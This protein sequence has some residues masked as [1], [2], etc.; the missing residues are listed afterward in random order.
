[1]KQKVKVAIRRGLQHALHQQYLV[2]V[3]LVAKSVTISWQ[4]RSTPAAPDV[5]ALAEE[6]LGH[7][8]L[9][10]SLS[11]RKDKI[12]DNVPRD[13]PWADIHATWRQLSMDIPMQLTLSP[14]GAYVS[15][16]ERIKQE[17]LVT[18][19]DEVKTALKGGVRHVVVRLALDNT[20]KWSRGIEVASVALKEG[21]SLAVWHPVG[22]YFGT[23]KRANLEKFLPATTWDAEISCGLTVTLEGTQY[24]VLVY[25][26]CDHMAR[27]ALG[28]ADAPSSKK[29][30]R[31][32]C[33]FCRS[34]P[35][36][37]ASFT[38]R[39]AAV[40]LDTT[41]R[42]P[43]LL[44]S[45][46][47]TQCPP[48][49]LHGVGRCV[50]TLRHQ[51][52]DY[53][54]GRR[55]RTKPKK[56]EDIASLGA[57]KNFVLQS[58]WK[59]VYS[60]E[61]GKHASDSSL[62][63]WKRLEAQQWEELWENFTR[64]TELLFTKRELNPKEKKELLE[65]ADEAI[66]LCECLGVVG[67]PWL[68]IFLYHLPEFAVRLGGVWQFGCWG[69]EALHKLVKEHYTLSVKNGRRK[70]SAGP[71]GATDILG[72]TS[73][74]LSLQRLQPKKIRKQATKRPRAVRQAAVA[75]AVARLIRSRV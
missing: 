8:A 17:A 38:R 21:H 15:L 52:E 44:P 32:P 49:L 50:E 34:S 64:T 75:R 16:Q 18:Q 14:P 66:L 55:T 28:T 54:A 3:D 45:I 20:T 71:V 59:N 69:V 51:T 74:A 39:L 47:I 60:P 63:D 41:V 35:D 58:Y 11:A 61:F 29:A 57:S 12:R 1:M 56:L 73:V 24:P 33:P 10:A 68:H 65:V 62:P 30:H 40:P 4:A 42:T 7:V 23:E 25:L 26:C 72:R 6:L 2:K 31:C 36:E 48:D 46:P 5:E 13:A 67:T 53:L 70:H 9:R 37:V 27:V 22:V 19:R 43:S